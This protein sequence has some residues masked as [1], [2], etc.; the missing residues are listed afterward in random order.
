M[1]SKASSFPNT[2]DARRPSFRSA[3]NSSTKAAWCHACRIS[4]IRFC[5]R[6]DGQTSDQHLYKRPGAAPIPEKRKAIAEWLSRRRTEIENA[7]GKQLEKVVGVLTPFGKQKHVL[8]ELMRQYRIPEK[9]TV[10][11]I[12]AL[13]GAD[14]DIVIFSPVHTAGRWGGP[15]L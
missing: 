5:P 12:H 14:R 1:T 9:M 7:Y 11:T 15:F 3:T 2:A 6:S 8:Q 10:G 4:W 13:Q